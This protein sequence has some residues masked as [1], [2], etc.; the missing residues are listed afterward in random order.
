[1]QGGS[2]YAPG[3]GGTVTI[4]YRV[5]YEI[6]DRLR[7][8]PWPYLTLARA[9]RRDPY[10]RSKVVSRET[11]LVIEGYP[12][13]GNTYARV[14]LELA[15]RSPVKLAHHLHAPAQVLAAA[16]LGVPC[17]VLIREPEAAVLSQVVREPRL[18]VGQA[19]RSYGRFHEAIEPVREA[20][21]LARFETVTADFGRVIEAV[22]ARSRTRFD[23]LPPTPENMERV[24]AAVAEHERRA[25]IAVTGGGTPSETREAAKAALRASLDDPRVAHLRERARRAYERMAGSADV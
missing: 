9:L 18:T 25:E 11:A 7:A 19:L 16:K 12:R 17:L 21:T 15:Q 24:R 23:T 10:G 6:A 2:G 5:R 3:G 13:S 4:G 22:N 20:F 1:M 14:A 8:S